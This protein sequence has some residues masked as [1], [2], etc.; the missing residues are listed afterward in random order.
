M[1]HESQGHTTSNRC[2]RINTHKI[3]KSVKEYRYSNSG[4]KVA[5]DYPPTDRSNP[6]K[7]PR[8]LRKLVVTEIQEQKSTAKSV[9]YILKKKIDNSNNN[10]VND[11][12]NNDN[13]N[14]N[15]KN[16]AFK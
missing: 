13:N 14:D 5:E 15:R 1:E 3:K 4:K 9:L 2:P 16:K 6:S 11:N 12:K 7:G 10:N 8:G